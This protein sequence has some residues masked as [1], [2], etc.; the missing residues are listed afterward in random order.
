MSCRPR[1]VEAL[2][3]RNPDPEHFRPGETQYFLPG[4]RNAVGA[5]LGNSAGCQAAKG[6]Y[7][8]GAAVGVYQIGIVSV[9]AHERNLS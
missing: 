9:V 6:R 8:G 1:L 2:L 3:S 7:L 4:F 5:P